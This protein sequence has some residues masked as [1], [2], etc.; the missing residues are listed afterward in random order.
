MPGRDG[1]DAR[2]RYA[3]TRDEIYGKPL[4]GQE[5]GTGHSR[6]RVAGDDPDSVTSA[7]LPNVDESRSTK[8]S[9]GGGTQC[10]G[11][12]SS[13]RAARAQAKRSSSASRCGSGLWSP[14]TP[15]APR[16][17]GSRRWVRLGAERPKRS[18][19]STA[20]R[21]VSLTGSAEL[22]QPRPALGKKCLVCGGRRGVERRG[23]QE[24]ESGAEVGRDR[25][26]GATPLRDDG[27]PRDGAHRGL[28]VEAEGG[29]RAT[30][31]ALERT[32]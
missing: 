16:W 13:V 30:T 23:G 22:P 2:T 9:R 8:R 28:Q 15:S 14:P 6:S 26:Q 5:T 12:S 25:R 1:E 19:S 31:V 17:R 11:R 29:V 32:R 3:L 10:G 27:K 24:I 20:G 7:D 18:T 21:V 4:F